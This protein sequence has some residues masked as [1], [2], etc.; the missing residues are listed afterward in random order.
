MEKLKI[1]LIS[2]LFFLFISPT[3]FASS[4]YLTNITDNTGELCY[5][6]NEAIVTSQACNAIT[7]DSSETAT[8]SSGSCPSSGQECKVNLSQADFLL[9][10]SFYNTNITQEE[11]SS[12]NGIFSGTTNTTTPTPTPTPTPAA[13]VQDIT[14]Q[15]LSVTLVNLE[16]PSTS[17]SDV[18]ALVTEKNSSTTI[19]RN[20]G[21]II[22][23]KPE[24]IAVLNPAIQTTNTITLIRGEVTTTVDCSQ[25]NDYEVRTSVA[26]IKVPGSCASGQRASNSSAQFTSNY[27]QN[28]LDGTLTVK[29]V[30]GTVN[31]TDRSG[32][33]FTLSDGDEKVIQST[34]PRSSWV[35]P[36]DGDYIYGGQNNM[37][38][39]TKYPNAASYL[40][41]YNIP[42]SIFAEENA[43]QVEYTQKAIPITSASYIERD[44]LI[45]F[46]IALETGLNGIIV[47]ARIFALDASSNIIGESVSSD[48][49]TITWKDL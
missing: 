49:T 11:C 42:G 22:E 10:F 18:T 26:N 13:Q 36:I 43:S 2:S 28:G 38:V 47:E 20:D 6:G 1:A 16:A 33:V 40:L 48:R 35:L 15:P 9:S 30:T 24:T 32:N 3:I 34:V 5:E 7:Q 4:C 21:S 45:I 19:K 31:V 25:A 46:N 44:D 23:I 8:F 17:V 12:V 27:S 41:E 37:L 29:V 14:G 39:W